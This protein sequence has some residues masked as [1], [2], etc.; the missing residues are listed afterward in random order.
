VPANHILQNFLSAENSP[1]WKWL[2]KAAFHQAEFSAP[3]GISLCLVI[4]RVELIRKDKEKFRSAR[5][6]A[7]TLYTQPTWPSVFDQA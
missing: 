3:S 1:E 2:L 4:S 5:K 6:T 7:F